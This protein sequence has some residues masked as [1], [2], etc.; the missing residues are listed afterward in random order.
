VHWSRS[1]LKPLAADTYDAASASSPSLLARKPRSTADLRVPGARRTHAALQ[2][3]LSHVDRPRSSHSRPRLASRSPA[4]LARQQPVQ[5]SPEV[6]CAPI[7]AH[8]RCS[9]A[10]GQFRTWS[11]FGACLFCFT[12]SEP[13][14]GSSGALSAFRDSFYPSSTQ[15]PSALFPDW[16]A[17]P[18][19][20]ARPVTLI[21]RLGCP[22]SLTSLQHFTCLAYRPSLVCADLVGY[23]AQ[24]Q[25][26]HS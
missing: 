14:A 10:P 13:F 20:H 23:R 2:R 26:L 1:A 25:T 24:D 19:P 21:R 15:H 16:C 8:A 17:V 4:V 9:L 22:I 18:P 11:T 3:L 12:C 5:T 6:S 7:T